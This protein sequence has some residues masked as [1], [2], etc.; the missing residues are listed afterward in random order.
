MR[1]E[2]G[3]YDADLVRAPELHQR[4]AF[5]HF[6]VRHPEPQSEQLG[7]V[8]D[9][10]E[11]GGTGCWLAA[12]DSAKAERKEP[13]EHYFFNV[14]YQMNEHLPQQVVAISASWRLVPLTRAD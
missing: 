8:F 9:L 12:R 6:L 4:Q 10:I 1:I 11:F 5:V 3:L 2:G 7:C 14:R 13:A